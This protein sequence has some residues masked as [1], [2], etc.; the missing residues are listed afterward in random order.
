[1]EAN[2]ILEAIRASE[3]LQ[4]LVPD[5]FALAA[6][7]SVG[8]TKPS[9]YPIGNGDVIETIGLDAANVLLDAVNATSSYRYVVHLLTDG[10]LDS[11][12]A[13]FVQAIGLL[14]AGGVLSQENGDKLIA[15]GKTA[16]VVDEYD[17]RCAIFNDDGSLAI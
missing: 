12:S 6:A 4:A 17:V 1:M 8:R 15:L 5:T 16:D 2:E 9:K 11:S 7:L 10:K 3:S 14:V 13:L